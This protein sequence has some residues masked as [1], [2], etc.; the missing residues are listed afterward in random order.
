MWCGGLLGRAV[1]ADVVWR[2]GLAGVD[3]E[4]NVVQFLEALG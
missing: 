4:G 1:G 3:P 2:V